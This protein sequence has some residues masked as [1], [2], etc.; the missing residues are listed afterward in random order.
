MALVTSHNATVKRVVL[1]VLMD[2]H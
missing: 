2:I 1:F